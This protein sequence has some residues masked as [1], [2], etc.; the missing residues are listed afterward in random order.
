[1]KISV[2]TIFPEMLRP[3]LESSIL[4]RAVKNGI[5]EI[6]LIN[7]RDFSENKH[8]NTDDYPFGGGVADDG[9]ADLFRF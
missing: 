7:I 5:L 9:P 3:M 8:H 6:E 2:L 4:G 1:M